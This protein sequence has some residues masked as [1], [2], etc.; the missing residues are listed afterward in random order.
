MLFRSWRWL[1]IDYISGERVLPKK[2][3]IGELGRMS[4]LKPFGLEVFLNSLI[5]KARQRI[6]IVPWDTVESPYKAQK[7][8]FWSGVAG[9]ARMIWDILRTIG[10][11]RIVRQ[12]Y[13]MLALRV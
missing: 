11:F 6:K 1:G 8:G 10:P 9:D 13:G 12:I 4:I 7:Y 2:L 3:V 5:L